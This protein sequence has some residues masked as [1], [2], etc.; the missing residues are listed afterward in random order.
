M[1]YI[2]EGSHVHTLLLLLATV[3]E[4]PVSSLHLLGSK[5]TWK[6]LIQKLCKTQEYC[7]K[8][9]DKHFRCKLITV[10]GKGKQKT[11]RLHVSSLVILEKLDPDAYRYY[12]THFDWHHFSGNRYHIDRH[13]RIAEALVMCLR[14]GIQ[15]W[16]H[17]LP[18]PDSVEVQRNEISESMFYL[19]LALKDFWEGEMNKTKFSRMVGTV[20]CP[21]FCFMVYNSRGTL[22]KWS[23]NGESKVQSYLSV[24][25]CMRLPGGTIRSAILFGDNYLVAQRTLEEA[26]QRRRYDLRFDNVYKHIHFIPLNEFGIK[27]LRTLLIEDWHQ[28]HR[29]ILYDE[30]EQQ[31]DFFRYEFDAVIDGVGQISFIDGDLCKLI[32][33][34]DAMRINPRLKYTIVCYPEQVSMIQE[35]FVEFRG[36]GRLG[37]STVGIDDVLNILMEE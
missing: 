32:R 29:D 22:M 23:G 4:Y 10:S 12:Q 17:K 19:S 24:Q 33:V 8:D 2:R 20:L 26:Q 3:G 7:L 18:D 15:C 11:I 27:Q 21:G 37:I 16:P 14:A 35:Y 30:E 1:I 5:R 25:F 31:G 34:R 13:H 6:T 28:A 9:A 36:T